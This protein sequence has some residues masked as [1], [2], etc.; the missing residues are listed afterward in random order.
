[1]PV[2]KQM[3]VQFQVGVQVS[4]IDAESRPDESYFLFSYR[5]KISN[6]GR[7]PA[8]LISRHW[9]ITDAVGKTEEV[10]GAGVVGLQP[11]IL[12]GQSFEYESVCPLT[13]ASGSMLGSYQ[14]VDEE[15][16]SFEV[17]IPEF[18]LVAPSAIH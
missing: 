18:Y 14:M 7:I 10:R 11:R 13:T 12:P 6:N 4:F 17:E 1:M 8:Q 3:N 2:Q 16:A 5:I 15:G 9:V